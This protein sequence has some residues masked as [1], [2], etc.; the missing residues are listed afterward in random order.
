MSVESCPFTLSET[1]RARIRAEELFREEIR[2]SLEGPP[3]NRRDRI[4]AALNSSFVLFLLSSIFLTGISWQYQLWAARQERVS[5][6]KRL[7]TDSSTE[8]GYRFFLLRAA[9]QNDKLTG[10]DA[11]YI[12]GVFF[13]QKPYSPGVSRFNE[14]S[15]PAIMFLLQNE[16]VNDPLDRIITQ[17]MP[18]LSVAIEQLAAIPDAEFI[19]ASKR[20]ELLDTIRAIKIVSLKW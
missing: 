8:L 4:W 11:R 6:G 9:L 17:A 10:R 19:D 1:D 13:G 16:S 5:E 20:K 12:R 2:A 14:V 3:P 15:V 7:L 18:E